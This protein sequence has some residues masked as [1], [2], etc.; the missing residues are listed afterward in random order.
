MHKPILYSLRKGIVD[1]EFFA[2]VFLAKSADKIQSIGKNE[3]EIVFL[4]SLAKP[5][6][7]SILFDCNIIKDYKITESELAIFS[8]SHTGTKKHC[9]II[10]NLLKRLDLKLSDLKTEPIYPLDMRVL[11]KPSK[12][13]NNC[14][15]KHS[16]MLIMSKY[17]G[18]DYN[19]L[20]VNHPI[21]QLIKKKQEELSG[22]KSDTLTFDGCGTPLWGLPYKNAIKAYF[23][24]F[25]TEK[26]EKLIRSILKHPDIFGGFKR[27]D[28]DI[29]KK[30]KGSLFSKTGAGG[31]LLIY[32][33]K[34]DEILLIKMAHDDNFARELIAYNILNEL[35]WLN[36]KPDMNIY[37]QKNNIAASYSFNPLVLK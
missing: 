10:K 24:L 15:G 18:A 4:R 19:Y 6:Q 26:Y 12:L 14:S 23:N 25:H 8:G 32:N 1:T 21:Q 37:N 29:I 28:S 35:G 7:A 27:T 16:M 2:S 3:D 33:F 22:Y 9:E 5:L 31:L 34:E 17:S 13:S 11:K 36:F 20:D 30:S